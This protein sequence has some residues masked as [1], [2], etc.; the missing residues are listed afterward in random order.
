[1]SERITPESVWDLTDEEVR[2]YLERLISQLDEY[3]PHWRGE[4]MG[5]NDG[6][7]EWN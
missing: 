7:S 4:L 3:Y 5:E 2:E 6:N 1:M